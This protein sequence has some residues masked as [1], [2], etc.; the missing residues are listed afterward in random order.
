[1]KKA[2]VGL[3]AVC[4]MS[5]SHAEPYVVGSLGSAKQSLD[6]DGVSN[7]DTSSTGFK[8]LGGYKFTPN[9]AIEGGYLDFGKANASLEGVSITTKTAGFGVGAAF[10]QDLNPDWTVSARLGLASL[11]T[12]SEVADV[13]SAKDTHT[14]L[15]GGLAVGYRISPKVALEASYDFSKAER[16]GDKFNVRMLGVGVNVAF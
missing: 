2:F 5:A 7:C 13:S 4:A 15:Y 11:K 3:L 8:L 12:K 10:H 1:L 14:Q 9:F 16:E 6:C